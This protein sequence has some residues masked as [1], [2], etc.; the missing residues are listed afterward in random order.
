MFHLPVTMH[1]IIESQHRSSI[2]VMVFSIL[3]QLFTR[4]VNLS[5]TYT[6]YFFYKPLDVKDANGVVNGYDIWYKINSSVSSFIK[7]RVK[8]IDGTRATLSFLK[9]YTYYEI[10]IQ[11]FTSAGYGPNSSTVLKRTL[12][13]GMYTSC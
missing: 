1:Y 2:K 8:P 6:F 11:A 10:K 13:G 5:F 3:C 4:K 9:P 7:K 12:E